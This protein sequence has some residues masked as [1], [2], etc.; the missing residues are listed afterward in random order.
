MISLI[1]D[2]KEAC[3]RPL[4]AEISL[5]DSKLEYKGLLLARAGGKGDENINKGA[6]A[7]LEQPV[8]SSSV[9]SGGNPAEKKS[10]REVSH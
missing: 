10:W 7:T 1:Q 8:V 6:A 5:E 4:F 9:S 3:R 2:L